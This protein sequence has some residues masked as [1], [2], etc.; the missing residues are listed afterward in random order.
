M[1]TNS[2]SIRHLVS[3]KDLTDEEFKALVD[4][5]AHFKNV[6]KNG[7]LQQRQ[8]QQNKLI[9]R[10]V[11]MLFSKRSTRTRISTEGA[12]AFFGAHP[13]FLG[14]HDIQLGVNETPYDTAR[15]ISSMAACIFARVNAHQDI[16][17][18]TAASTVPVINAL[19]DK[20]HPLQAI[21]D[22]LTIKEQLDYTKSKLK[23]AWVGDANNVIH[24]MSVA[25]LKVGMDVAVATP[26]SLA[27]DA[28][29]VAAAQS[30]AAKNGCTLTLTNDPKEACKDAHVIVTDTF[31][32]MGEEDLRDKKLKQFQG[33]QVNTELC[34]L[35]APNHKF[36]HCLPRHCEEVTDSVFYGPHSIVFEEAENRLYAAMAVVDIF[37]NHKG[38][39]FSAP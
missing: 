39:F 20:F 18:L 29:V 12:A 38:D 16:T 34:A 13:M 17:D 37:V 26:V 5:A 22:M 7:D 6:F 30:V 36:M 9:G 28:D 19:C 8:E 21:C 11:A 27:M 23:L 2:Q 25:A 14:Q 31:I 15:V 32:S 4:R 10:T 35:A 33:F 1:S 3:I 24:D